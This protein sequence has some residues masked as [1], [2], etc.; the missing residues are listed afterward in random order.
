MSLLEFVFVD[1]DDDVVVVVD[2]ECFFG[3]PSRDISEGIVGVLK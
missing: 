3:S 1:D 2:S